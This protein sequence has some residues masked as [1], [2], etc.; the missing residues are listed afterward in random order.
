MLKRGDIMS[1]AS[2]PAGN[3]TRGEMSSALPEK[4]PIAMMRI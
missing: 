3:V 2:G 1:S 4:W